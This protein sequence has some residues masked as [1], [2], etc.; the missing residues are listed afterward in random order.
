MRHSQVAMP[1]AVPPIEFDHI[2]EAE[3]GHQIKD[4][5]RHNNRG[6]SVLSTAGLLH[7]GAQRWTMQMVKVSVRYQHQVDWGQVADV[8][9]RLSQALQ[10]EQPA[11]KVRIDQNVLPANLDEKTGVSN[12]GDS[13]LPI[14]NQ[15]W[16]VDLAG[17]WRDNGMP[18]QS[19]KLARTSLQGSILDCGL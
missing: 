17:T 14:G 11:R 8:N 1:I 18:H 13:K 9:S 4:M 5:V 15:S 6:R 10:H 19:T 3:V 7:D 16:F 2:A 12:E